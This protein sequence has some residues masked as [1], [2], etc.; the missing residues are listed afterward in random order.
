M[1]IEWSTVAVVF[2]LVA[3]IVALAA[4]KVDPSKLAAL[5]SFAVILAGALAK[6]VAG[7]G[8]EPKP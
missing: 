3:G 7:K 1:K 2:V 6:M 8:E 4:F 5:A